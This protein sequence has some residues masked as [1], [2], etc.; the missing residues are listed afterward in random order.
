MESRRERVA[1]DHPK[2]PVATLDR[3]RSDPSGYLDERRTHITP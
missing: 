1:G 2:M 3:P